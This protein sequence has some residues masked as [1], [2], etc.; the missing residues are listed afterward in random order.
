MSIKIIVTS[1]HYKIWEVDR[2]KKMFWIFWWKV[3]SEFLE[4]KFKHNNELNKILIKNYLLTITLKT[5]KYINDIDKIYSF[6]IE[7]LL[8]AHF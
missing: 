8:N 4:K 1:N 2:L 3:S 6:V 5:V 7:Y